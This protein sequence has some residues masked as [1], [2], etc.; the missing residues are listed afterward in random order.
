MGENIQLQKKSV[1]YVVSLGQSGSNLWIRKMSG[2]K[3]TKSHFKQK[4]TF[5]L[6]LLIFKEKKDNA[7][8]TI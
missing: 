8:A 2:N 6:F 4:E 7:F 1:I 5:T 3:Q